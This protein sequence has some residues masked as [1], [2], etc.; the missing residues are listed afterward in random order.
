MMVPAQ[1]TCSAASRVDMPRPFPTPEPARASL[2]GH[3]GI[4][5]VFCS[6]AAVQQCSI[7]AVATLSFEG[8]SAMMGWCPAMPC[9]LI[10]C[11]RMTTGTWDDAALQKLQL[12][13]SSPSWKRQH[14]PESAKTERSRNSQRTER[15]IQVNLR[16]IEKIASKCMLADA[17]CSPSAAI[18][19]IGLADCLDAM[20]C[21]SDVSRR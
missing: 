2:S 19:H 16:V 12:Q 11:L 14:P 20:P 13:G 10:C 18:H 3:H 7:A 9:V 6:S 4:N 15:S 17:A 1:L 5:D 21:G 8:G